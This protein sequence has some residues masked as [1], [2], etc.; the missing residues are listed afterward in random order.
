MEEEKRIRVTQK[1]RK[2]KGKERKRKATKEKGI[3][4][5]RMQATDIK[6]GKGRYIERRSRNQG[7]DEERMTVEVKQER[8]R[9][10]NDVKHKGRKVR[11][12][13]MK[14]QKKDE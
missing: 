10:V 8:S 14:E 9:A 2:R 3:L 4:N 6:E 11:K 13:R 12:E 5:M 1:V 7:S